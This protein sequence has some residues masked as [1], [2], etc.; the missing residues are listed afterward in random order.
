V[1]LK[2]AVYL[3]YLIVSSYLPENVWN[4]DIRQH[5]LIIGSSLL[6]AVP[7]ALAIDPARSIRALTARRQLRETHR[8]LGRH[9]RVTAGQQLQRFKDPLHSRP[10]VRGQGKLTVH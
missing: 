2:D 5:W 1:I 4:Y 8:S 6:L 10:G 7:L 9:P 3:V